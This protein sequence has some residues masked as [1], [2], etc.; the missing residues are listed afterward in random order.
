MLEPNVPND[1]GK[2]TA[3]SQRRNGHWW[4]VCRSVDR[5]NR[6]VHHFATTGGTN[7]GRGGVYWINRRS[8]LDDGV[9]APVNLDL[10]QSIVLVELFH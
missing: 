6:K 1:F 4:L 5:E 2:C 7:P 8:A 10:I 3:R 9:Q